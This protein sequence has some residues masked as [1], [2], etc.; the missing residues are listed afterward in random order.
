[1]V[2]VRVA[3]SDDRG[4]QIDAATVVEFTGRSD[5]PYLVRRVES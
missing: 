4:D 5:R 2:T 3:V 1:M